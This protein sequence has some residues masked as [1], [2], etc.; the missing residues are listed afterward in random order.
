[1]PW[2]AVLAGLSGKAALPY[3]CGKAAL[4]PARASAA[5]GLH[6]RCKSARACSSVLQPAEQHPPCWRALWPAQAGAHQA[7]LDAPL[8]RHVAA[9]LLQGAVG[10]PCRQAGCQGFCAGDGE[11]AKPEAHPRLQPGPSGASSSQQGQAACAG[12]QPE[13]S[14][15]RRLVQ[16]VRAA[17][18]ANPPA[19]TM[20]PLLPGYTGQQVRGARASPEGR[21]RC[22]AL[23]VAGG[24][25]SQQRGRTLSSLMAL[26]PVRQ[27]PWREGGLPASSGRRRQQPAGRPPSQPR[28]R[29]RDAAHWTPAS[30]L[31]SQAC[32]AQKPPG[33][34]GGYHGKGQSLRY[35]NGYA[36]TD[37]DNLR[38]V[39]RPC[40]A[41]VAAEQQ[42]TATQTCRPPLRMTK[43]LAST[44]C[45]ARQA[46]CLKHRAPACA[47][48]LARCWL[49][50]AAKCPDV[51]VAGD[52]GGGGEPLHVS[53]ASPVPDAKA[54]LTLSSSTLPLGQ[55]PK[56]VEYDRQVGTRWGLLV[57]GR[58]G[59][60][61]VH[62]KHTQ[63]APGSCICVQQGV[64]A[65]ACCGSRC[66]SCWEQPSAVH[67]PQT[68]PLRAGHSQREWAAQRIV[69]G[70]LMSSAR[71]S[72]CTTLSLQQAEA[73]RSRHP[74]QTAVHGGAPPTSP[75]LEPIC[76]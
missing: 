61:R 56:W 65:Q 4:R 11:N 47:G 58:P 26:R 69:L 52:S 13:L 38:Q 63:A 30:S 6:A 37:G 62:S 3:A 15:P 55:K 42:H 44:P 39:G 71:L 1:M 51:Q 33:E 50:Q 8:G 36:T 59:C 64:A 22:R 16:G 14:T 27:Q 76:G 43:L 48:C 53:G 2:P 40:A 7:P 19:P 54:S 67:L 41:A 34:A 32:A 49:G 60:S 23:P 24:A 21:L 75:T 18:E 25:H 66:C 12:A 31:L 45:P 17:P 68:G 20:Q 73:L 46:P 5:A 10:R 29:W 35:K 57:P 72:F 74:R 70:S 9:E 28:R